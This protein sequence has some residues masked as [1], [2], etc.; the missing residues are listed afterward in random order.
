[1]GTSLDWGTLYSFSLTVAAAPVEGDSSLRVAQSG[2]PAAY[3]VAT[4]V[5]QAGVANDLIFEDGFE[6]SP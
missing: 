5:P 2:T 4:L 1:V 6:M 3:D